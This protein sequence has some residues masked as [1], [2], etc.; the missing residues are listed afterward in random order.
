MYKYLKRFAIVRWLG[1]M[2]WCACYLW[3][4]VILAKVRY[5]SSLRR[6]RTKA[7]SDALRVLFVVGTSSKWKAQSLYDLMA[8][9][10]RFEPYIVLVICD[11][12]THLTLSEKVS[13]LQRQRKFF[14]ER[15]MRCVEAFDAVTGNDIDLN[16]FA[17]D[18]VFY[19]QPWSVAQVQLPHHVAKSALTFYIPYY[20]PNYGDLEFD[21]GSPFQRSMFVFITL[22][23]M[24][25]DVY[26]K[27]LQWHLHVCAFVPL[28][29]TALD[30]YRLQSQR[31]RESGYVVYAPHWSIP[32]AGN[33]NTENFSTFLWSG[34][35]ILEYAKRHREFG[36]VF[37][38]HPTLKT[39]LER[40]GVWSRSAIDEYWGAWE[41]LGK[42]C[43]D[44]NYYAL[45]NEARAMVTDCGSFL[46]EFACTGN[47]IIYIVSDSCKVKPLPASAKLFDSYYKVHNKD[48]LNNALHSIV[49]MGR[50]DMREVRLARVQ[51][52]GLLGCNAAGNIMGY[53]NNLLGIK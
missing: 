42:V 8:K 11:I 16:K 31:N 28:G 18:I 22:N 35:L 26:R 51:E 12:E 2:R 41:K 37:K 19:H 49:E 39:V 30:G 21:C 32:C 17:P 53:L 50:D 36:W 23:Q 20:V 40:T 7:K 34:N 25:A 47:P 52:A 33:E 29:H 13:H 1:H 45:F 10:K 38:P 6:L 27:Y 14:E 44:G 48:E 3:K 24:W 15:G 46:V 9:S 4:P 43:Y 5:A